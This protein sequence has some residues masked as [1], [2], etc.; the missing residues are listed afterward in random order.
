MTFN[1]LFY[2]VASWRLVSMFFMFVTVYIVTG[3]ITKSSGI[4]AIVQI[5][6]TIIHAIFEFLW[7]KLYND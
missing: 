5:V 3:D 4:T 2:K 7:A 1:K 6:Q